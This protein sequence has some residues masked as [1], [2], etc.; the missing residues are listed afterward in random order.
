[1]DKGVGFSFV[2]VKYTL[3]EIRLWRNTLREIHLPPVSE[4]LAA[5]TESSISARLRAIFL[6]YFHRISRN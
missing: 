6:L 5:D 1:M 4:I 3:G 2:G